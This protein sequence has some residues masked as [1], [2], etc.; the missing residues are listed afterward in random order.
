MSERTT[1]GF[2]NRVT[3]AGMDTLDGRT[4]KAVES[5]QGGRVD[6]RQFYRSYAEAAQHTAYAS[7]NKVP[8]FREAR[9]APL[10]R[11]LRIDRLAAA[12]ADG[13]P[14]D[15]LIEMIDDDVLRRTGVDIRGKSFKNGETFGAR[16]PV[17]GYMSPELTLFVLKLMLKGARVVAITEHGEEPVPYGISVVA[18]FADQAL[19]AL[20]ITEGIARLGRQFLT[21]AQRNRYNE[22]RNAAIAQRNAAADSGSPPAVP[23]ELD[24]IN[25]YAS[26]LQNPVSLRDLIRDSWPRPKQGEDV[27]DDFAARLEPDLEAL[28][29]FAGMAWVGGG[30]AIGDFGNNTRDWALLEAFIKGGKPVVGICYGSTALAQVKDSLTGAYLLQGHFATG[31]GDAD[32]YTEDTATMNPDGT[33]NPSISGAA[34]INLSDMLKQA[35]GPEE[36]GYVMELDQAPMAVISGG[37]I[38]TGNTVEDGDSTADLLLASRLGGLTGDYF[39]AGDGRGRVLTKDDPA[40]ARVARVI[41]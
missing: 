37:A 17:S 11:R 5:A 16:V 2:G 7:A 24:P 14:R 36:G 18:P 26:F 21:P 12:L 41:G 9:P 35:I 40:V 38:I 15:A 4:R 20:Q 31:H 23:P 8:L 33:Y 28:N 22:A 27:R 29:Q 13:T 1:T 25:E 6:W 10:D 34:P 32:N 3:Y 39:I 19:N 30:G